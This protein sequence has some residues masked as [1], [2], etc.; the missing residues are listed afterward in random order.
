MDYSLQYDE[1]TWC[2][3]TWKKNKS[4]VQSEAAKL[5][6]EVMCQNEQHFTTPEADTQLPA[7]PVNASDVFAVSPAE[8]SIRKSAK[9]TM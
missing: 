3:L 7:L 2:G 1:T 8:E 6:E 5:N 4:V 9:L